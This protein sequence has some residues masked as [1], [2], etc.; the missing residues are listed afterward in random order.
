MI[1]AT[2]NKSQ[3]FQ[4]NDKFSLPNNN[5]FDENENSESESLDEKIAMPDIMT[6]TTLNPLETTPLHES[7]SDILDDNIL[8]IGS[9]F[10]N[11]IYPSLG[12]SRSIVFLHKIWSNTYQDSDHVWRRFVKK[13]KHAFIF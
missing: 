12:E 2:N 13:F 8:G 5:Y 10:G 11:S 3:D 4:Y 7:E 6:T 9:N 1:L